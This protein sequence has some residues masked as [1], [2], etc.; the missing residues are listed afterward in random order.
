MLEDTDAGVSVANVEVCGKDVFSGL[1]KDTE[2]KVKFYNCVVWSEVKVNEEMLLNKVKKLESTVIE[3][4][5]PVRVM[6]RRALIRREREVLQITPTFIN[7]HWF[8]LRLSTTAGTYVKE[9][10]TGDF[11]RTVPSV[12]EWLG[13]RCDILQ[14]DCTGIC[15]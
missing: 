1:Q 15:M 7:D 3:Q 11:G 8:S 4:E 14:L 12:A 13:G 10:V 5:T 9:F 6:H 2:E